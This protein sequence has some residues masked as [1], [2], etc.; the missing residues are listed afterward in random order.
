MSNIVSE[1]NE[2]DVNS[3]ETSAKVETTIVPES[4]SQE[5]NIS[6]AEVSDGQVASSTADSVYL[7]KLEKDVIRYQKNYIQIGK[8]LKE[9][10]DKELYKCKKFTRFERY[11]TETFSFTVTHCYRLIRHY[12]MCEELEENYQLVPEK[13]L[14]PLAGLNKDDRIRIW[15]EAKKDMKSGA[16]FPTAREVE[17]KVAAFRAMNEAQEVSNNQIFIKGL[18]KKVSRNS[19]AKELISNT[20]T[21][22][23]LLKICSNLTNELSEQ[24]SESLKNECLK[25]LEE[26][27]PTSKSE[28]A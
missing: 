24:D 13:V 14:R 20:K 28:A 21:A 25:R 15:G 11:C 9:I 16:A 8:I 27:F 26:I 7:T 17:K 23:E 5:K 3:R 12:E 1:K 10:K 18:G 22:V 2:I 6:A 19:L 4:K